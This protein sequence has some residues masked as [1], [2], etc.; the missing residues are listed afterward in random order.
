MFDPAM[1]SLVLVIPPL[2]GTGTS[3]YFGFLKKTLLRNRS[4]SLEQQSLKPEVMGSSPSC[5]GSFREAH[6]RS[7][8]CFRTLLVALPESEIQMHCG[9]FTKTCQ[10]KDR[11]R[12]DRP[13]TDRPRID[14]LPAKPVLEIIAVT[15]NTVTQTTVSQNT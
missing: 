1:S 12:I 6:R 2:T 8:P 3:S 9:G 15:R 5:P 11:S 14:R 13:P 10:R 7:T 4:R